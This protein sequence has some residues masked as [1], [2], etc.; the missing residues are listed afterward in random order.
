MNMM[1]GPEAMTAAALSSRAMLA[2]LKICTWSA[3]KLD[4]KVTDKVNTEHHAAHDAG[5]YN[6]RLLSKSATAVLTRVCS[7][8]RAAHYARTLPWQDDGVRILSAAAY[9]EYAEK[10]AGLRSQFDAAAD[11]FAI[12]YAEFVIDER[13][14]LNGMFNADDYPPAEIIRN[15]FTFDVKID[16]MPDA[17]DFRVDLGEAQA[18]EIRADIEARTKQALAD[19]MRDVWER[20]AESVGHMADRLKNYRP[21]ETKGDK[22]QGIFR[23]SLV[24]NIR[25]LVAVLPGLNVT[26]DPRLAAVADRLP[27]L[28]RDDAATLRDDATARASVAAEAD[29]ILKDVSEYLA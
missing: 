13:A 7:E 20:V 12:G 4:R 22:S 24:E 26:G 23:D 8:A 25:D 29:A 16:V 2:R 18:A 11:S 9:M 1:V 14:R 6:K 17:S 3:T 21:A 5:R 27:A 28:C 15:R 10:M 19:A